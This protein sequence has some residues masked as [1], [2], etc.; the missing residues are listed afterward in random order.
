MLSLYTSRTTGERKRKAHHQV[1]HHERFDCCVFLRAVCGRSLTVVV[2]E[3]VLDVLPEEQ[4]DGR[5]DARFLLGDVLVMLRVVSL[6]DSCKPRS[7][8]ERHAVLRNISEH[9]RISMQK[10]PP[11]VRCWILTVTMFTF[12]DFCKKE[13]YLYDF[14]TCLLFY[15]TVYIMFIVFILLGMS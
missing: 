11:A 6:R 3:L 8:T 15:Y 2:G 12:L 7:H 13:I 10:K 5:A 1:H 4:P 9:T 14:L